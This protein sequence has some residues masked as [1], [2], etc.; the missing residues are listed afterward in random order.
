MIRKKRENI[1]CISVVSLNAYPKEPFVYAVKKRV[2]EPSNFVL[3][4]AL[5]KL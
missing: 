3:E 2:K 1:H 5:K 4:S